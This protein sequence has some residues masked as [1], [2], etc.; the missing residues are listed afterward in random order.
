MKLFDAAMPAPNP[1]RVRIFL[2]EKGIDNIPLESVNIMKGESRSAQLLEKNPFGGIPFLELDDGL[3]ISES[4]A[5]CRYFEELNP[6]VPLFGSTALEKAVIEMWIRRIELNFMGPVGQ[7][8]I[9]GHK[10]TSRLL[11]Q[12]PEAAEFGRKRTMVFY[13]LFDAHLAENKFVAGETYSIADILALSVIDF[14]CDLVGVRYDKALLNIKRWHDE[15]LER[16]SA[17]A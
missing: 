9:H 3:V 15:M 12:I 11:K 13:D 10:L 2:Q 8:W 5:I 17:N 4:V 6:S 1:R 7:V 14:A 16:P